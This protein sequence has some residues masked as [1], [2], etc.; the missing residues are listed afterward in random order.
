MKLKIS[1]FASLFSCT[2]SL[3]QNYRYEA[4][5]PLVDTSMYYRIELAPN[6]LGAAKSSLADVRIYDKNQQEQPY[7]LERE[8]AERSELS[9]VEYAIIDQKTQANGI[10]HLV[11]HNST[12]DTIDNVSIVVQ[13]TDVRK[14]AR[15]SGSNDGETWFVIKNNYLLH[16]MKSEGNTSE[17]KVLNFPSSDYEYFRLEINDNF[18]LPIN[19]LKVGY[20]NDVHYKGARVR[21]T[22]PVSSSKDSLKKSYYTLSF[23]DSVYLENLTFNFSGVDYFMRDITVFQMKEYLTKYKKLNHYKE[24]LIATTVNSNSTNSLNLGSLRVKELYVEIDNKDNKP[25]ILNTVEASFLKQYVTAKLLKGE[26]YSLKYG[27]NLAYTPAYDLAHFKAEIPQ[28][29][30]VVKHLEVK[31]LVIPQESKP[32]SIFDNVYLVWAVIIVVGIVL[33]MVSL[34]MLKEL[35]AKK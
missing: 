35:Q 9:F 24:K 22:A 31:S 12:K 2:L 13:N 28:N 11:F 21:F 25:L 4:A 20:Y 15:L 14:R 26:E 5:L 17:F 1:L 8:K 23:P 27:N 7:I 3:A 6:V 29:S 10:S 19:I 34:K 18:R 33:F 30:L 32:S 16:A